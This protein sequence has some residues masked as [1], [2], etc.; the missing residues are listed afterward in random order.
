L[1]KRFHNTWTNIEETL[2]KAQIELGKIILGE[3]IEKEKSLFKQDNKSRYLFCVSIDVGWN[4]RGSGKA[5]N[6]DLGHHINVGNQSGLVVALHYMSKHCS[7]CEIG[8]KSG[9]PNPHEASLCARNYTGSLKG[10]EAHGALHSYLLHI[11]RHHNVVY[12]IVV[13]Y[14]NSSTENILSWDHN[15]ALA[16]ANLID[17]IPKTK[18]GKKK[19]NTGKLP[20]TYPEIARLTNHSHCN[21][22]MADK[23]YNLAYG[24]KCISECTTADAEH[25]KRNMMY[26][27][28]Q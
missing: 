11:H 27:L 23:C 25:L 8:E 9:Q 1:W 24:A 13:M 2:G 6:S 7:K 10:V 21:Q 14:D 17:E 19:V 22:C 5:Y 20:I 4:N 12:N 18:G 16:A 3:N 15:E 28:H 26:A